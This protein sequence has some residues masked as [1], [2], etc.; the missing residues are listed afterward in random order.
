MLL[1]NEKNIKMKM[2]T[3]KILFMMYS[4]V[5]YFHKIDPGRIRKKH[6]EGIYNFV[7]V[8]FASTAVL[9]GCG[10]SEAEDDSTAAKVA[11]ASEMTLAELEAASQA[12][13]EAS[14]Q[15]FKVVGLTSTLAKALQKFCDTYEWMEYDVNTFVNN[16]YK[17]YALLTALE[18]ADDNYFADFALVQDARSLADYLEAGL[19]STTFQ[20][21]MQRSVWPKPT[22]IR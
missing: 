15:T 10:S 22:P 20:A 17:D 13:M 16:S 5:I 8:L 21:T 18:Q 2:L 6:E 14:D 12:E 19:P 4:M 9:A 7:R 11:E 1:Q 3:K